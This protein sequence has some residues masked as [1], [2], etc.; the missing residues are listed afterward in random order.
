MIKI[1][2]KRAMSCEWKHPLIL[3]EKPDKLLRMRLDPRALNK[4]IIR[5][6]VQ[7][8]MVD[9]VSNKLTNI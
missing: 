1:L 3:I 4:Y 7:I 5:D 9:D 2:L 8:S 6:M